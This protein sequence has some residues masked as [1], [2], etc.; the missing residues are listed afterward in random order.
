MGV[1]SDPNDPCI[2]NIDPETNMQACYLVLSEEERAKGYVRP[3]RTTSIHDPCG[4]ASGGEDPGISR[5]TEGL[6]DGGE[7]GGGFF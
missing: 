2:Q 3:L 6:M 1:T 4:G 5:F 7:E